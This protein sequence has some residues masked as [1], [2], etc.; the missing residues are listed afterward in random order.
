MRVLLVTS[1]WPSATE[2]NAGIFV[3]SQVSALRRMGIRIDVLHFVGKKSMVRYIKAFSKIQNLLKVQRYDVVHAHFGQ[4]GFLC[5][6]Q[7]KVPVVVTFHGSELYGLDSKKIV[8][9]FWTALMRWVSLFTAR[10]A[11]EV[12]AVSE[13]LGQLL[14]Q[15]KRNVVPMGIDLDLFHPMDRVCAREHLGWLLN[16]LA[17]LFVGDPK[18]KIKRYGL[19]ADAIR[20][21]AKAFPNVRLRICY[22]VPITEVPYYMNA[23][24]ILLI[25]S[26]HESGPLV[27]REAVACGLPVVSVDVGDVRRRLSSIE[28]CEICNN[29]RPEIIA[30]ALTRALE[31]KRRVDAP[32]V[33]VGLDQ[34]SVANKILDIYAKAIKQK[35]ALPIV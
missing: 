27:A 23:A 6:F 11:T 29:D 4:A 32:H 13:E 10:M 30:E 24:D 5:I 8:D 16:E 22:G 15:R 34:I 18:N 17:I 25:T 12:I 19:A 14:P 3:A 1:G 9:I 31:K 26:S 20:L 7:R 33:L 21:A 35:A 2:P 28:D